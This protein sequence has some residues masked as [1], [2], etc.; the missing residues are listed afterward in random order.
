MIAFALIYYPIAIILIICGIAIWNGK[1]GLIHEYH[2][3]NVTDFKSYGKA[4]GK[5]ISGMGVFTFL[6]A[7]LSLLGEKLL[8]LCIGIFLI[9]IILMM[10]II[11]FIQKKYNG[12]MFS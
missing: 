7:S 11:Y 12:G 9:G 3:K 8:W 1:T 10:I 5:A 4:M 2:R 6:S